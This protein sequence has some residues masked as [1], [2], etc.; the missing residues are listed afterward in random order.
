MEFGLRVRGIEKLLFKLLKTA[1]MNLTALVSFAVL[2]TGCIVASIVLYRNKDLPSR[3]LSFSLFTLNYAVLLIFLFESKYIFYVPFLFRT[4]PLLYYL[5]VPSFYVYLVL[6]LKRRK[7]LRWTDALHLIPSIIYLVDFTPLFLS[8]V[9]Y[10]L[11]IINSLVN[12]DQQTVLTFNEGWI[13]PSR[14]HFLGPVIIGL[15][16][17]FFAARMLFQYYR[18]AARNKTKQAI[19]GWLATAISLYFLLEMASLAIFF[20]APAHQWLLTA[21]AVLGFFFSMSLILFSKPYI[22]YGAY[23]NDANAAGDI[24]KK[25]GNPNLQPEKL[26]ELQERFDHYISEQH[27]LNPNTNLK[28]VAGRLNIPSYVLSMF[29]HQAY[30]MHFNDVINSHRVKYVSEGLT[31]EQWDTLTLEAVGEIAGFNNR[32]TFLNAFKKFTGVTPSQ[33]VKSIQ[34]KKTK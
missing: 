12:R 26:R 6:V 4:G 2:V 20:F 34:D 23:L 16:Y 18:E 29:V 17:I 3:I 15:A 11:Q 24:P 28:E 27:Y 31:K 5:M 32:I 21:I 8:P 25:Q 22:L 33:Y 19:L 14:I 13:M 10:K 1:G 7:Q 30:Q 9:A